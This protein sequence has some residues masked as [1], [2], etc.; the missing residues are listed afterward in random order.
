M[1]INFNLT[2]KARTKLA[3]T[4]SQELNT[5]S[6]YIKGKTHAYIIGEYTIDKTGTLTG[7]DNQNLVADLQGLHGFIPASE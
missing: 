3:K 1:K 4:I 2:G 5:E 7:P 6:T